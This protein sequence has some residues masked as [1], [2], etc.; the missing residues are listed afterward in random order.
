MKTNFYFGE[1]VK[2]YQSGLRGRIEYHPKWIKGICIFFHEESQH[3]LIFTWESCIMIDWGMALLF[4]CSVYGCQVDKGWTV[5]N[6]CNVSIGL[7][8]AT[9]PRIVY[10]AHWELE[11]AT[12]RLYL[13]SGK[14]KWNSTVVMFYSW[15]EDVGHA[16]GCRSHALLYICWFPLLTMAV[17]RLTAPASTVM[18]L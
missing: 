8:Q 6:L 9:F 18:I 3:V 12:I 14:Q 15:K 4:S 13:I 1:Q 7:S 17:S 16:Q 11:L 10:F 5:K 2:G